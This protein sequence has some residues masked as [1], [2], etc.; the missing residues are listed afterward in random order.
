MC[1]LDP[2]II[3]LDDS[4]AGSN[5]AASSVLGYFS[6]RPGF[7]YD[8]SVLRFPSGFAIIGASRQR[9]SPR[10][11]WI[12]S[13]ENTFLFSFS[14]CMHVHFRFSR[15]HIFT[16]PMWNVVRLQNPRF[17]GT[18]T[19]PMVRSP[20]AVPSASEYIRRYHQYTSRN[21]SPSSY[22]SAQSQSTRH[23]SSDAWN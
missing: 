13:S 8:P 3:P 23:Q 14:V 4:T 1:P 12:E 20:T 5:S 9:P 22:L 11:Q 10:L 18:M 15:S 17:P 16:M 6:E 19:L 7:E 21:S 2:E